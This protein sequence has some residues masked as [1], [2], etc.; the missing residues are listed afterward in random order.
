MLV[1]ARFYFLVQVHE[2]NERV[3]ADYMSG[4]ETQQP[5][6]YIALMTSCCSLAHKTLVEAPSTMESYCH[7]TVCSVAVLPPQKGGPWI[8]KFTKSPSHHLLP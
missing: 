3:M 1:G 5:S 7:A 6:K 8:C 4:G 2:A